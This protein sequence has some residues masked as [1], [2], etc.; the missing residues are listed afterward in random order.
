[1]PDPDL[2][3]A[4]HGI[5]LGR[6]LPHPAYSPNRGVGAQGDFHLIVGGP[7]LDDP[8]RYVEDRIAPTLARELNHHTPGRHDLAGLGPTG[9]DGTRTVGDQIGIGEVILRRAQLGLGRVHLGLGSLA[10]LHGL[11][12]HLPRDEA[13]GQQG[14]EALHR[15][16][17]LHQARHC[18][19]QAG[20]GG[21]NGVFGS[22]RVQTGNHLAGFD[23]VADI[24]RTLDQL[25]TNA[26]G[27]GDILLRLDVA[28]ERHNLP[29]GALR[30]RDHT[31]RADRL[32]TCRGL[33]GGVAAGQQG[34]E[35]EGEGEGD[36][37]PEPAAC[38]AAVPIDRPC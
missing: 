6:D 12:K 26:K 34:G 21:R 8:C 18:T 36:S 11:V 13:L 33:I 4:G 10:C 17:R 7:R 38:K 23:P 5:G 28:A 9:G 16:A 20:A 32:W 24:D 29:P 1:M 14:L 22:L 30:D 25:A 15:V 31:H 3:G 27:Q 35:G 19:S 2:E 37:P